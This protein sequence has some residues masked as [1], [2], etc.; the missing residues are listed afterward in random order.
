MDRMNV[1]RPG[2]DVALDELVALRLRAD[3]LRTRVGRRSAERTSGM[4]HSPFRGRGMDYAESRPYSAGD[5]VRHI[6]WRVTARSGQVHTKL[7]QAERE[8]VTAIALDRSPPMDF[9]TRGCFKRVQAARM[10]ALLAWHARAEGDRLAA[11]SFGAGAAVLPPTG[12]RRGVFELLGALA[13]WSSP[14]TPS[15]GAAP[16]F[17]ATIDRL[18][19]LLRP[20]SHVLL[21][22]DHRSIDPEAVRGLGR[23]RAHHDVAAALIVDPIEL[24]ALPDGRYPAIHRGMRALLSIDGD[25]ARRGWE[26]HFAASIARAREGLRRAGVRARCVRTDEDPVDALRAVLA[27]LPEPA[28]A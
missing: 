7:F 23:L 28:A 18:G 25:A 16:S 22:V 24:R 10:A 2:V 27:G 6:D 5:D 3:E 20:G 9:G 8:R 19:R 21:L 17:A 12:G 1:A 14:C 26:A 4:R 15:A 11:A 13:R